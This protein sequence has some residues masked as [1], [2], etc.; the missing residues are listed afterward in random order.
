MR[1]LFLLLVFTIG[2]NVAHAGVM[3]AFQ[4]YMEQYNSTKSAL[5]AKKA[6]LKADQFQRI[7]ASLEAGRKRM[8]SGVGSMTREAYY[9][10]A[11][12]ESSSIGQLRSQLGLQ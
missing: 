4:G 1:K 12:R 6:N 9:E 10:L 7:S 8:E 2:A 3:P 11:R 5:D